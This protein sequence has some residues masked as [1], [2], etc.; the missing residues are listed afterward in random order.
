[1]VTPDPA[2]G[3]PVADNW[4]RTLL[5]RAHLASTASRGQQLGPLHL[6][7]TGC[8]AALVDDTHRRFAGDDGAGPGPGWPPLSVAVL[9]NGEGP[10]PPLPPRY[11]APDGPTRLLGREGDLVAYADG[12]GLAWIADLGG[13]RAVRWAPDPGT[14]PLWERATPL[15]VA[16]HWW[17]AQN[18]GALLHAGAVAGRRGVALLVGPGGAGK[19]TS[20]MACVGSDLTVL[21]DDYV[22]LAPGD[23]V[24]AHALYSAGKLDEAS[25]ALLPDLR[26]RVIGT[27]VAGKALI[28]LDRSGPIAAPQVVAICAVRQTSGQRTAL[29]PSTRATVLRRLAPSS[30]FQLPGAVDVVFRAASYA[31]RAAE[32]LELTVGD[33]RDVPAV[34]AAV[35]G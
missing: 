28:A 32:P 15:R 19:S 30:V 35:I 11:E 26:E 2:L 23:G 6:T 14:V 17:A 3:W 34:L 9:D 10:P 20:T 31:V 18:G 24:S 27:G 21:G 7:I 1:M 16:L 13:G 25:M 4:T 5:D 22:L 33:P 12:E 8:D 29:R